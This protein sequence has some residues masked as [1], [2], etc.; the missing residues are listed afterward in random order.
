MTKSAIR[1]ITGFVLIAAGLSLGVYGQ[2]RND[3][4]RAF[5]AGVGLMKT[6]V[7]G[8][9]E[10]FEN[11]VVICEQIGDSAEDIRSKAIRVLPSL[12]FNRAN[13]LLTEENKVEES[14]QASKKA[15]EVAKKYDNASVTE[16]TEKI[17]VL[18]YSNMASNYYNKQENEK[19]VQAFDSVLMI[20]PDHL[21]SLYNKALIYRGMGDVEH[22]KESIDIYIEKLAAAG[23]SVR[24]EQANVIAIDYLR[25]E[26]V[27][28]IQADDTEKALE[29]LNSA[30]K[31][32][33]HKEV[34]YLLAN[35]SNKQKKFSDAVENARLGLEL[36]TG[37]AEDKAKFY[38]EMAEAQ[39]AMGQTS[40]A[41][42]SYKNAA[43]GAFVEAAN[44]QLTNLKC[45]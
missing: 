41:C 24:V 44:A 30:L 11:C 14:I 28:A 18:A 26:A 10:S 42:A 8:A 35:I 36:E 16:N 4:I 27:K 45:Q 34:Y 31:Y 43:Y 21:N 15:L 23:D 29:L 33:G 19:A 12:Y 38:F 6:D 2:V 17:L 7:T 13:N 9:I 39:A 32:G 3:A 25:V 37:S 20:N 5:N 40:N 1:K 22:F